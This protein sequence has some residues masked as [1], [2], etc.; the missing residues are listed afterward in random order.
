[1]KNLNVIFGENTCGYLL[2]VPG[3]LLE[4]AAAGAGAGVKNRW[5]FSSGYPHMWLV[6]GCQVTSLF[7]KLSVGFIL[8][9]LF[10]SKLITSLLTVNSLN[11]TKETVK[12][13]LCYWTALICVKLL[14]N[15]Q[16]C[17]PLVVWANYCSLSVSLWRSSDKC[18]WNF[19]I[20][21]YTNKFLVSYHQRSP[22]KSQYY[23]K[24]QP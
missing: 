1:M 24:S 11:P 8:P 7:Q 12:I 16:L 17:K 15:G 18:P 14:S 22:P 9:S 2:Q 23:I 13:T 20:L 19:T 6:P 21:G 3:S 5:F 10:E 4:Q